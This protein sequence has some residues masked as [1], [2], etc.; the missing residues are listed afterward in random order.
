MSFATWFILGTVCILGAISPGPSLLIVVQHS[1]ASGRFHALASAWSHATGVAVW[2]CAATLGAAVIVSTS[3][4]TYALCNVL[5]AMYLLWVA[6]G[7]IRSSTCSFGL[8]TTDSSSLVK[9]MRDGA[10]V[11]LLNPKLAIFFLA[12]FPQFLPAQPSLLDYIIVVMTAAFIDGIW[13]TIVATVFSG[14]YI[15]RRLNDHRRKIYY[16]SSFIISVLAMTMIYTTYVSVFHH[17]LG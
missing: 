12:V 17:E 13:Y 14:D 3:P 4:T 2:A 11:S 15:V 16:V 8:E 7:W 5:G 1:L 9:A 10:M 6:V